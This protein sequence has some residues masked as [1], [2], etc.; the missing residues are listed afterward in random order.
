LSTNIP[1]IWQ[2]AAAVNAKQCILKLS[3]SPGECTHTT[4]QC[5]QRQNCEKY[6]I[7]L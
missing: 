7:F 5:Y 1:Q 2:V 3:T 4:L 6:C